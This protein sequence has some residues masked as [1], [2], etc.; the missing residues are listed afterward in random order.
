MR[1]MVEPGEMAPVNLF[2]ASETPGA[3][4]G[5]VVL[6]HAGYTVWGEA[7][8]TSTGTSAAPGRS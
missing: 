6:V 4:T 8:L 7:T 3:V 1:R 5:A 2:P